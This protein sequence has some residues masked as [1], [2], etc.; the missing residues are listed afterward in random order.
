VTANRL[1][2]VQQIVLLCAL[3]VCVVVMHHFS[4]ASG[5]P[6]AAGTT[7]MHATS[8]TGPEMLG[9]P[10]APGAG[11]HDPGTPD[12]MHDMVHLCLAVL[13]AAGALLV[14]LAVFLGSW[15]T[16]AFPRLPPLRGSPR[17]GRP[18]DRGGRSI[19]TSLCV[20][21]T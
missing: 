8:D 4:V 20:L 7:A 5:M 19:L 2:K 1:A 18:P 10:A 21:R 12:G 15:L 6:D 3:A 14:A 16:A 17:G 11:E 13:C 9:S